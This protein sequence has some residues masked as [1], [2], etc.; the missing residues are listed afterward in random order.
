MENMSEFNFDKF[1]YQ[2]KA[3]AFSRDN[4]TGAC[5]YNQPCASS[6]VQPA[7]NC[8]RS[9]ASSSSNEAN[10]TLDSNEKD[11]S[12][13]DSNFTQMLTN[14]M[15][16][17]PSETRVQL[18]DAILTSSGSLEQAVNSICDNQTSSYGE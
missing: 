12:S 3:S 14:M 17:F 6:H 15:E 5:I 2:R 9:L 1:S 11:V 18:V 13:T 10:S 7:E 4:S 16:L 8:S